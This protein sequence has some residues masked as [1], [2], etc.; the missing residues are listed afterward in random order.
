MINKTLIVFGVLILTACSTAKDTRVLKL[1]SIRGESPGTAV[2]TRTISK[3]LYAKS[4][5]NQTA[6][7]RMRL[8]PILINSKAPGSLPEYR[9]FDIL[10][11]SAASVLGLK[12]ADV[13]VAANDFVIYDPPKFKTY[14]ALLKNEKEAFIE[15]RREGQ[16]IIFK[17]QFE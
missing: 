16:P 12:N 10:P 2:V 6:M 4:I 1:S 14:L 5:N 15:I 3:E 7:Q 13:L 8:V 11:D 9:L 17:Y